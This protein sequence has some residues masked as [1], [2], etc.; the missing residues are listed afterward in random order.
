MAELPH[1]PRS[2]SRSSAPVSPG[3]PRRSACASRVSGSIGRPA[4][5]ARPGR[6][7]ALFGP[8]LDLLASLG[9]LGDVERLRRRCDA[10]E[11]STTPVRCSRRAPS[12][13]ARGDRARSV[14]L[15]HRERR[16]WRR[17]SPGRSAT[18]GA[19]RGRRRRLRLAD[20][21]ARLTLERRAQNLSARLV[22]AADG[23]DSPTRKAAGIDMSARALRPER[24]DPVPAPHPPARRRFDRVSHPRGPFTLVPCPRRPARRTARAS[25]G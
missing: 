4:R 1:P 9:L 8:T 15:E 21:G 12:N 5:S 23:R 11:S 25:S 3:S 7:V 22:V 18:R 6:T 14:R 20:D 13:S 10:C 17:S 19:I 2:T 16:F 24:A